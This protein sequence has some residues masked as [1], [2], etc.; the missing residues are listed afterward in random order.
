M[1]ILMVVAI[2]IGAVAAKSICKLWLKDSLS[3]D[4]SA[5]LIDFS[6]L[7]PPMHLLSGK[8][9][10]YSRRPHYKQDRSSFA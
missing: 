7:R 6:K 1:S 5:D 2:E 3:N 10:D 8:D 9:V 4:I